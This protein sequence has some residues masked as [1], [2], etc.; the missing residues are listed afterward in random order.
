MYKD[1]HAKG[2]ERT[3]SVSVLA[4]KRQLARAAILPSEAAPSLW[5]EL[6]PQRTYVEILTLRI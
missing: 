4:D 6:R 5:T 2:R 3:L 1:R